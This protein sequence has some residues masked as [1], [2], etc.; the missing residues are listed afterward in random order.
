MF[1]WKGKDKVTR[2]STINKFEE[3]GIKM[4]DIETL[5]KSL[6]LSC[7]K[8]I[9]SNNSGAWRNFLEHIF[10]NSGSLM[11]FQCNYNVYYLQTTAILY[12][13]LLKWW[14]EIREENALND[15]C[16]YIIWNNQDIRTDNKPFLYK[17]FYD[18]G[19]W[20]IGDLHFDLSNTDSYEQIA[21]NV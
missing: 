14:A 11:L 2:A 1:L 13:E 8:R 10:K 19:I 4:V 15:D 16:Y 9:F 7:L 6:R 21:Q 3:G 5:T 18:I 12:L 20:D 17:K